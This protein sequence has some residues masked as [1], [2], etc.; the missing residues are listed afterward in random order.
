[1][2]QQLSQQS[3]FNRC[4]VQLTGK[5]VPLKHP[6]MAN[7]IQGKISAVE[8]CTEILKKAQL[9]TNGEVTNKSDNEGIEVLNNFY[10]FH[11]TWFSTNNLDTVSGYSSSEQ[12]GTIDLYDATEPALA[13]TFSMFGNNQKY[14]DTLNRTMGVRAIRIED[15][16]IKTR[17]KW[18]AAN[19]GRMLNNNAA[20]EQS[21]FTFRDATPLKTVVARNFNKHISTKANPPIISVGTLVGI[22]PTTETFTIPNI[23]LMPLGGDTLNDKGNLT[24]NLNFTYDMFKTFG[25]GVLGT[26]IY[27]MQNYGH[28]MNMQFNGGNKVPRR[29][30]QQNMQSFLCASLPALREADI[31]KFLDTK[32]EFPFR[33]ST[34]CL[35]C[36]STLDPMAYTARNITIGATDYLLPNLDGDVT[37]DANGNR[38]SPPKA[39]VRSAVAITS[40][41]AVADSVSGWPSAVVPNFHTQKPSGVLRFR[42]FSGELIEKPVANITGLG[43]AMSETDDYYQC[44]AKRYFEF[45]TGIEVPLYDRTNPK[46]AELNKALSQQA[47]DDRNFVED[48]AVNL[49]NSQSVTA[50]IE[51][52]IKSPY[53]SKENF[54]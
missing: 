35:M 20:M 33:N 25:G 48:L 6:M 29:W 53:Y 36:H 15:D 23:S 28:P 1:M 19:P 7:V 44:A 27:L 32:S 17:Q 14:S 31:I 45:M 10:S 42:S 16:T 3:L 41:K 52:I 9:G 38:I 34:S 43:K 8:A 4:Y 21:P 26:P 39:Y 49:R 46:N 11:R 30:S 51:A 24:P 13:L 22:R 40:Y 18:V 47:I 37:R 12:N 54:R 2:A 50:L 5:P